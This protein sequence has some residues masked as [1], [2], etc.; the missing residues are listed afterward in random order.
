ML[1]RSR[2]DTPIG[3]MLLVHDGGIRLFA[4]MFVDDPQT[5]PDGLRPFAIG[6]IAEREQHAP[7]AMANAF[8]EYFA[9]DPGAVGAL[10]LPI[11]GSAFEQSVWAALRAIPAGQTA[12][13][14]DIARRLGGAATGQGGLARAVGTANARNPRAIAVPCHRVIGAD[15]RLTGYAGGLWRKQWLL[16]HEGWAPAQAALL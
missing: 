13:Y 12:S 14:G 16:A 6:P 15:G 7:A 2:I 3:P 9:G 11:F 10:E 1:H 4:A 5:A 8:S